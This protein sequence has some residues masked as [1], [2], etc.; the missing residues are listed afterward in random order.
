MVAP[1]S[2]PVLAHRSERCPNAHGCG[3]ARA[4]ET[5]GRGHEPRRAGRWAEA[6]PPS[7]RSVV[8]GGAPRVGNIPKSDQG[9]AD[10]GTGLD[11]RARKQGKGSTWWP[12][13]H[14]VDRTLV[15]HV[16]HP[17]SLLGAPGPQGLVRRGP[18]ARSRGKVC[19][20]SSWEQALTEVGGA[21]LRARIT[22]KCVFGALTYLARW[23]SVPE[24]ALK[25]AALPRRHGSGLRA[26]RAQILQLSPGTTLLPAPLHSPERLL[27]FL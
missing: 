11:L 17:G 7:L 18:W 13:G 6:G 25:A 1:T 19:S 9:E 8:A 22:S 10:K 3:A 2:L 16:A 27:H 23:P 14:L 20:S 12:R 4:L 26:G 15:L 21:G 5:R 24:D